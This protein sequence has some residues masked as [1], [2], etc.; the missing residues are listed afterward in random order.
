MDTLGV[1][2]RSFYRYL[3]QA[4]EHDRLL[5]MEQERNNLALEQDLILKCKE[6]KEEAKD[7]MAK[8]PRG[9]VGYAS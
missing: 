7:H 8:P 1:P 6:E 5:L 4:F 2:E 9:V 3:S